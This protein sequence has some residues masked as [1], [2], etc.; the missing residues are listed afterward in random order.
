MNKSNSGEKE[1]EST[2]VRSRLKCYCENNRQ[3]H[4]EQPSGWNYYIQNLYLSLQQ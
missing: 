2:T 1:L 3:N 4:Q